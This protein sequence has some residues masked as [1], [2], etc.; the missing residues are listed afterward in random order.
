MDAMSKRHGDAGKGPWRQRTA[1][2]RLRASNPT[3]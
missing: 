2:A 3:D 1:A